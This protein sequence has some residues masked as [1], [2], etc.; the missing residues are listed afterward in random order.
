MGGGGCGYFR[1]EWQA[2]ELCIWGRKIWEE[3]DRAEKAKGKL[4][5]PLGRIV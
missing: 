1:P 3:W 5:A 2:S 4:G